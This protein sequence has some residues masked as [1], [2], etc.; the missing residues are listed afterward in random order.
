MTLQFHHDVS[1]TASKE[2]SENLNHELHHKPIKKHETGTADAFF[3]SVVN[4]YYPLHYFIISYCHVCDVGLRQLWTVGSFGLCSWPK[5]IDCS[6]HRP[7]ISVPYAATELSVTQP[8]PNL[9]SN[10]G[11]KNVGPALWNAAS[12]R[13]VDLSCLNSRQHPYKG[14]VNKD[15]KIL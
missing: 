3:H 13:F 4:T 14:A 11:E 5:L 8:S 6:T 10:E 2:L 12:R 15:L 7:L 9:Y 1:Q